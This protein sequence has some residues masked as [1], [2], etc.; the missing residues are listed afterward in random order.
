MVPGRELGALLKAKGVE[1]AL[2]GDDGESAGVEEKEKSGITV[3]VQDMDEGV[4]HV[5]ERMQMG[6]MEERRVEESDDYDPYRG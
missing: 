6:K 4:E 5:D 2:G 1:G 3:V